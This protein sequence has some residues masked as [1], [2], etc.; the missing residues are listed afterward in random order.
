MIERD[1]AA[2]T[3]EWVEAENKVRFGYL[4]KSPFRKKVHDMV[5]QNFNF[6]KY[7]Q[8]SK[9]GEN[10][11]FSKNNGLQN[12]S[13]VYIQKGLEGAPEIFIDPNRLSKEGTTALAGM[14]FSKDHKYCAYNI[15]KAG[16]DWNEI[17]VMEVESKRQMSNETIEWVKFSGASWYKDGF[18]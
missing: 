16:S 18:Y 7:S 9:E 15:A 4:D 11:F 1:T 17:R 2:D 6:E 13:V 8:P 12:Q 5:E 3:K 14:S 10:Y